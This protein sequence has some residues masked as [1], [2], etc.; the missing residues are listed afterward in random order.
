MPRRPSR[1][2]SSAGWMDPCTAAQ[3]QQLEVSGFFTP[4]PDPIAAI[5]VLL[6]RVLCAVLESWEGMQHRG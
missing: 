3:A 5:P 2:S 4:P 6:Y 1:A